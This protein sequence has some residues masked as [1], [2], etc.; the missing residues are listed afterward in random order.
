ME[1]EENK[2]FTS[3]QKN[4]KDEKMGWDQST[5]RANLKTRNGMVQYVGG[6]GEWF[7][8]VFV[9]HSDDI[10]RGKRLESY[11]FMERQ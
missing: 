9:V 7:P 5:G 6:G 8:N 4:V 10:F 1:R 2:E 3:V 11:G